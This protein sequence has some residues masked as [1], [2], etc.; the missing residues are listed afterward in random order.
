MAHW[1]QF[2]PDTVFHGHTLGFTL[3]KTNVI[4]WRNEHKSVRF[5]DVCLHALKQCCGD[6]AVAWLRC[7]RCREV[8]VVLMQ[9]ADWNLS[10]AFINVH[11]GSGCWMIM[12]FDASASHWR[13]QWKHPA[14]HAV[15]TW[16]HCFWHSSP[17]LQCTCLVDVDPNMCTGWRIF[18]MFCPPDEVLSGLFV[19]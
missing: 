13:L 8:C 12:C 5:D 1:I 2:L 9:Y 3:P 4:G 16:T 10:N 14:S 7:P 18:L 17:E 6:L 11:C 15:L 19:P